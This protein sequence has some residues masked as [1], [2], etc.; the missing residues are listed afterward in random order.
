[1]VPHK[2]QGT[3]YAA[4]LTTACRLHA[5]SNCMHP[6]IDH[7]HDSHNNSETYVIMQETPDS[8]RCSDQDYS[9]VVR[10]DLACAGAGEHPLGQKAIRLN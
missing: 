9:A 3:Q 4:P 1:M 8:A 5:P 2:L 7:K 10:S 6:H